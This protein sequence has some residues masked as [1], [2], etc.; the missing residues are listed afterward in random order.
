M[1]QLLIIVVLNFAFI[2]I[3]YG[4]AYSSLE[5]VL[6]E[7][8]TENS[9]ED[10][11]WVFYLD[12]ANIKEIK[13]PA[14]KAIMPNYS[15]YKVTLTNYLGYHVNE[16]TC[17]VLFDSLNSKTILVEPIWYSG[18][19]ES[20][21]KLFL[22]VP[23]NNNN[24]LL[25]CLNELNELMEI[26]SGYKFVNT[27]SSNSLVTYDLVYYK[28]DSYTT[29]GSGISSTTN[30]IKD[31]VWRQIEIRIKGLKMI[32]YVSINPALKDNK[33]YKDN[34]KEIIR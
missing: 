18:I 27:S 15:F 10:G 17:V 8:F 34:Y 2:N 12:K 33:E 11:R 32:E 25:N 5:K 30:Y 26:G 4:Q 16:G 24:D 7:R 9:T 29:S 1:K 19:N 22:N 3:F 21:I 23:F 6:A 28:G 31:G 20:L 14:I 13:K